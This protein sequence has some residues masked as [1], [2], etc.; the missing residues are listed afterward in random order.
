MKYD[1]DYCNIL[2]L[3]TK[4]KLNIH[5]IFISMLNELN[6]DKVNIIT[7]IQ[8]IQNEPKGAENVCF[9]TGL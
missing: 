8:M 3:I 7:M 1:I 6:F 9:K 2:N 4:L 5:S